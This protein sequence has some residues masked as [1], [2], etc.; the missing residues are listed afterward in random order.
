MPPIMRD[1]SRALR[2]GVPVDR[3]DHVASLDAGFR[4]RTIGLRLGDKR[5]FRF[6]RPRLSAM[7]LV[8]GW[9]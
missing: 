9:I 8:T 7:S 2:T 1:N 5:A 3:D 4:G 6:F